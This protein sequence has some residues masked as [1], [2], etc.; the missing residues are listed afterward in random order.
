MSK[1]IICRIRKAN[2]KE[3]I[4]PE[5]LGGT[6]SRKILCSNCNSIIGHEIESK[7]ER[8]KYFKAIRYKHKITGKNRTVP[9][10]FSGIY[11]TIEGAGKVRVIDEKT[12]EIINETN[13]FENLD[14]DLLIKIQSGK[15]KYEDIEPILKKI[16][17]RHYKSKGVEIS[18]IA[19]QRLIQRIKRFS[20]SKSEEVT[21]PTVNVELNQEYLYLKLLFIK[22][23]FEFMY[24]YYDEPYLNDPIAHELRHDLINCRKEKPIR[25]CR[26]L[27]PNNDFTFKYLRNRDMNWIVLEGTHVYVRLFNH[28]AYIHC[29]EH[30]GE[31]S[32]AHGVGYVFDYTNKVHKRLIVNE[33]LGGINHP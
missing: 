21:L 6:L 29:S 23:A 20:Y 9:Y 2:S 12:Y 24:L 10:P 22:I 15:D 4:I 14:G 27:N 8:S 33:I 1:C 5:F 13:V 18:E 19:I 32:K 17:R 16:L 28:S 31:F 26:I 30:A 11:N 25:H 3:H 7:L